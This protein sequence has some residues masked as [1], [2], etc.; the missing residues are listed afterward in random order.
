MTGHHYRLPSEGEWE[1]AARAATAPGAYPRFYFGDDEKQICANGNTSVKSC[2]D[3]FA[4][5]APAGSFPAN[6]FGLHDTMGNVWEFTE[7]CPTPN[8][9]GAPSEGAIRQGGDCSKRIIRGAG[10]INWQIHHLR[11]ANRGW[12]GPEMYDV[13]TGFR[14]V[15]DN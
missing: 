3:G 2:E 13:M 12:L 1:Y 14:V 11:T 5:T 7:E 15:R 8:Y 4:N 10:W 6:A 9:E